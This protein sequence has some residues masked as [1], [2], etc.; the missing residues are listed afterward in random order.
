MTEYE[1]SEDLGRSEDHRRSDDYSQLEKAIAHMETQRAILG[2]AVVDASI[3][4]LRE[5]LAALAD[6]EAPVERLAGE[7]RSVSVMFADISGF[8]ALA[9]TMDPEAVRDLMN[10][11]FERLV[12]VVEKYE[13]VVDKFIGDEVMALFG[14]PAAHENDPERALRAALEMMEALANFNAEQGTDLRLHFGINTG[15]V[16]AGGIGTHE[17]REYSVMGDAVNLAAR[18][19]DASERGEILVGLDTH[20]LTEPL[21]EF[22]ALEPIRVKGK[23]EPVPVYRL[24]AARVVP[25]KVRGITG[26][27]SPRPQAGLFHRGC[28]DTRQASACRTIPKRQDNSWLRPATRAAAAFLS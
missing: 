16:I 10:A 21:F 27:E 5:K 26:L 8:T 14:A 25:G 23:A 28:R 20:R 24:L 4:A 17:R 22:E 12:P 6:T 7:R 15:L 2:D 3:A 9:E 19:E 11:C 13:G 18:L 1:P